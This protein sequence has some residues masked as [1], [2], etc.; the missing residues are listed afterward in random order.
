M[1]SFFYFLMILSGV[2]VA[3][4]GIV[5]G[6]KE[7]SQMHYEDFSIDMLIKVIADLFFPLALILLGVVTTIIF[8]R[9]NKQQYYSP[10]DE[11][12][13]ET[14]QKIASANANDCVEIAVKNVVC[15]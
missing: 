10:D 12:K 5:I 4:V 15:L 6:Y 13:I 14:S 11:K 7:V 9:K 1:K 8:N 2:I 3:L